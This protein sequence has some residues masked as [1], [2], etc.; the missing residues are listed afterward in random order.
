MFSGEDLKQILMVL[1]RNKLLILLVT[2]AGLFTGLLYSARQ[3]AAEYGYEATVTLSVAY[4]QNLGQ[5]TGNTV[6][7]SYSEIVTG[8]MVC[9]RAAELLA[10]EKVTGEQIRRMISVSAGNNSYVLKISARNESPRLAILAANAVADSF[11]AQ[12]SVITGSNTIQVLDQARTAEAVSLGGNISFRLL[13]PV[14]AFIMIC[15][16]L[17]AGELITDRA[18]SVKQCLIDEGELLTVIPKVKRRY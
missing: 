13:A 16:L 6:I 3:P 4:G 1:L 12:V 9:E 14:A 15:V 7:S 5:I 8:S 2:A 17:I 18:R 10:G 11:I